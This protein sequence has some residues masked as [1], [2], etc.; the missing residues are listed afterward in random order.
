LGRLFRKIIRSLVEVD[1]FCHFVD[2]LTFA[3][4]DDDIGKYIVP[5]KDREKF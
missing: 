2:I 1:I 3:Y 5:E 4:L